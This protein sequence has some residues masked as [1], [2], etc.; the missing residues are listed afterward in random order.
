MPELPDRPDLDQLRHQARELLRAAN[1][2]EPSAVA[3][4]RAVSDQVT[5]SAAQLAVARGYGCRSWP[6]LKAEVE[7]RPAEQPFFVT[8]IS[9]DSGAGRAAAGASVRDARTGAVTDRIKPPAGESFTQV[10]S[11]GQGAFFLTASVNWTP[12]AAP[13][14]YRLQVDA[15]GRAG[16]L[17]PVPG[18][19][20]PPGAH[21]IA[22]SPG[23]TVV[24]YT[25]PD[26]TA[27]PWTVE[28][29]LVDLATGERR[30]ASL[31]AGFISDLSLANDGQTLAFLWHSRS[32]GGTDVYVAPAAASD[33][34]GQG[35]VPMDPGGLPYDAQSPVIS[36]DGRA[37]YITVAQPE[38][39]G[40]PRW[41]RLLEVPAGGGQPRILFELRY[42]PHGGN[43]VYMW[44]PVCRNR[45]GDQLLAFAAGYVYRIGISSGTI[46]QLPFPEGQPYDAA[47]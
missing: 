2:G 42:Q 15:G 37:V 43:L 45:A 23:G 24:A 13:L 20:L 16:Q 18:D 36:A 7:R 26:R 8:L 31:P 22:A 32:A 17:T 29:A 30:I 21:A 40:G 3:R 10:T 9:E 46:A 19:L 39:T 47:W 28:A 11:D 1:N 35:R 27:R 4:V 34:V 12:D 44:G 6:A 41:T 25:V 14:V 5:L 38:P 33:W